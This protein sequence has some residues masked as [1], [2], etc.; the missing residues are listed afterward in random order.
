MDAA[1][2]V[3]THSQRVVWSLYGHDICARNLTTQRDGPSGPTDLSSGDSGGQIT[4]SISSS[5]SDCPVLPANDHRPPSPA[6]PSMAVCQTRLA[7][8]DNETLDGRNA[9]IE[10]TNPSRGPI[11]CG[12]AI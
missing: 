6:E 10:R 5:I 4:H 7:T 1:D 8:S 11:S 3:V 12:P 9:V 2:A